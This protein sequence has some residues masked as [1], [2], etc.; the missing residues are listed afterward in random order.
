MVVGEIQKLIFLLLFFSSICRESYYPHHSPFPLLKSSSLCSCLCTWKPLLVLPSFF[1]A[2]LGHYESTPELGKRNIFQLLP[3]A[4]HIN[5]AAYINK[6]NKQHT[7]QANTP[8][9]KQHAKIWNTPN[10]LHE[11]SEEEESISPIF[12]GLIFLDLSQIEG[13]IFIPW[14]GIL[15]LLWP[16][17]L[18][19]LSTDSDFSRT[20]N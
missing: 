3:C 10:A 5:R 20:W 16:F 12:S 2:K 15:V 4:S 17:K 8:K 6:Q 1:S 18:G 14:Y 9:N 11:Q 19:P 7:K 13:T